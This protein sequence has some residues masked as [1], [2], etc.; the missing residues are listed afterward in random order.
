M[1]VIECEEAAKSL[2]LNVGI[3]NIV[4]YVGKHETVNLPY[5]CTVIDGTSEVFWNRLTSDIA[6]GLITI[7]AH[8]RTAN[9]TEQVNCICVD[10]SGTRLLCIIEAM[11]ID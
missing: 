6:C 1:G 4:K 11:I 2:G 5:G 7:D 8:N 10:I 3:D 9:V